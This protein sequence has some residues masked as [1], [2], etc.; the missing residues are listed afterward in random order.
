ML[1]TVAEIRTIQHILT[2]EPE[3]TAEGRP[4]PRRYSPADQAAV[5]WFFKNSENVLKEFAD[6]VETKRQEVAESGIPASEIE[7]KLNTD[8]SLFELLTKAEHEVEVQ[9]KTRAI[10]VDVIRRS[11]FTADD[12]IAA[13]V[14]EKFSAI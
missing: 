11:T 14:C 7:A 3:L 1:L 5:R 2:F 13:S 6:T 8:Q 10:I 4:V 9:E 12:A